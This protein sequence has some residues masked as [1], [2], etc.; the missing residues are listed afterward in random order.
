[1]AFQTNE[2]IQ[3]D[4]GLESLEKLSLT[5]RISKRV[6]IIDDDGETLDLLKRLLDLEGFEVYLQSNPIEAIELVKEERFAVVITDIVMPEMSGLEVLK[7]ILET[8]KA[9]QVIMMTA[10]GTTD[11][12]LDAYQLGAADFLYKPFSSFE[13]IVGTVQQASNRFVKWFNLICEAFTRQREK[14]KA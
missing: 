2:G 5:E 12:T 6:L 1:M 13:E 11:K 8:C 4:S 9:T 7:Q 10:E 3:G 14:N